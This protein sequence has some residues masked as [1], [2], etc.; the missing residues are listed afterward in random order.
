[1]DSHL[2]ARCHQDP[3]NVSLD[4]KATH[5]TGFGKHFTIILASGPLEVVHISHK[6]LIDKAVLG[7]YGVNRLTCN[8][9]HQIGYSSL[10]VEVALCVKTVFEE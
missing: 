8:L 2:N 3:N 6:P 10:S 9:R 1:M 7:C 4:I 5:S